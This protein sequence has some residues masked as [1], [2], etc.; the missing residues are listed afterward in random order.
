MTKVTFFN[1][2]IFLPSERDRDNSSSILSD[3]QESRLG[4]IEVLKRRITPTTIGVG[5]SQVRR[6]KVRRGDDDRAWKTPFGVV[7]A[8]HFVT[9]TAAQ[10]IV[11]Q[12]GA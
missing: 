5:Q 2:F 10:A 6:A 11:E 8:S 1:F 3:M 4:Q 12:S 7:A 9:R